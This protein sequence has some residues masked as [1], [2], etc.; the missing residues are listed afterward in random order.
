MEPTTHP[1]PGRRRTEYVRLDKVLLAP[2]NPK[3]HDDEGIAR[4]ISHHGFAELPLRDERTG[5]LVAGHGRYEQ[6]RA[7]HEAGESPPDGID[8]DPADGMWLMPVTAGWASRSDL[9]AEAYLVG[10]NQL[11]AAGGVDEVLMT[12]VLADLAD[13]HLLELTGYTLGDYEAMSALYIDHGADDDEPDDLDDLADQLGNG[14]GDKDL[15][16]ALRLLLP[17][18]LHESWKAH[19]D[20]H[21]GDEVAAF[22]ALLG[23]DPADLPASDDEP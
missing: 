19:L 10:S 4:A 18:I 1:T 16:P 13:A 22:A 12:D 3:L 14:G 21:T 7:M 20:T 8:V 15:W 23:V 9:D 2:R 6:L 17:P 11:S 5:R